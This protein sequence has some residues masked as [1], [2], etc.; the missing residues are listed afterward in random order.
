MKSLFAVVLISLQLLF[1]ETAS[2]QIMPSKLK[3][4]PIVSDIKFEQINIG[5]K[6][7]LSLKDYENYVVL[8]YRKNKEHIS[9]TI[10]PIK[11]TKDYSI[12]LSSESIESIT[13]SFGKDGQGYTLKPAKFIKLK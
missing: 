8:T 6:F 5:Y 9:T 11:G 13:L 4:F 12:Y 3:Q 7:I 1:A 10:S 2:V